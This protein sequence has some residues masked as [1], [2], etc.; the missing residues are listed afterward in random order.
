MQDNNDNI[1]RAFGKD[2]D[3]CYF[4]IEILQGTLAKE[5]FAKKA[6]ECLLYFYLS[7]EE[8][9]I[10]VNES[11][12]NSDLEADIKSKIKTLKSRGMELDFRKLLFLCMYL[13]F[14]ISKEFIIKLKPT[15]KN[16][17]TELNEKEVSGIAFLDKTGKP[18][19]TTD[20]SITIDCI[21]KA[22]EKNQDKMSYEPKE[23][24]FIEKV[25]M[26]NKLLFQY[27]FLK[28]LTA[29]FNAFFPEVKRKANSEATPDEQELIMYMMK[30]VKLVDKISF[31]CDSY[32]KI[33]SEGSKEELL[34]AN[35]ASLTICGAAYI[36]YEDWKGKNKSEW[37]CSDIDLHPMTD[38]DL[39]AM[40]LLGHEKKL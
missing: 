40:Y 39:L 2:F 27:R 14:I 32:R 5:F 6:N 23:K 20:N 8:T 25:N 18:I 26:A 11:L 10:N 17:L 31:P 4:F 30:V 1:D 16:T 13:R 12:K 7:C 21:I 9:V 35:L 3:Y 15:I 28:Y 37:F 22:L 19:T 29:F 34:K 24:D 33:N 38:D 36:K